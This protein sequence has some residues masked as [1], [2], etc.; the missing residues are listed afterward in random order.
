MVEYSG[1][2]FRQLNGS[3]NSRRGGAVEGELGE[4]FF[5]GSSDVE[6][7]LAGISPTPP[8]DAMEVS[9]RSA[10]EGGQLFGRDGDILYDT[11]DHVLRETSDEVNQQRNGVGRRPSSDSGSSVEEIPSQWP[12]VPEVT[13]ATP[14]VPKTRYPILQTHEYEVFHHSRS[15]NLYK[16]IEV[17]GVTQSAVGALI[18]DGY[19]TYPDPDTPWICPI[20][21][22]R[23]LLKNINGLGGHFCVR[24]PRVL[25]VVTKTAIR[26]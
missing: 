18:P 12:Q 15:G 14:P 10:P 11:G 17:N 26:G 23:K 2:A 20:R 6:D 1:S 19:R 5:G 7:L 21:S 9:T 24:I 16:F 13:P 25:A 4:A 8:N 22:C 3:R